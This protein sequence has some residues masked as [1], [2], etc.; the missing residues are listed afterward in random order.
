MFKS[1]RYSGWLLPISYGIDLFLIYFFAFDFS[2]HRF[3]I[4]TM[5]SF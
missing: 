1:G 4:S 5:F 3:L 2:G